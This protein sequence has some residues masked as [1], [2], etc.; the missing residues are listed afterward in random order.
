MG[1]GVDYCRC[2]SRHVLTHLNTVYE[3]AYVEGVDSQ[4]RN[5]AKIAVTDGMASDAVLRLQETGHEVDLAPQSLDGFDAVVI[6]SATKMT[7]QAIAGAP[8]L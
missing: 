1:L 6:R 4:R 2:L 5:M 3:H 8:S 7:A